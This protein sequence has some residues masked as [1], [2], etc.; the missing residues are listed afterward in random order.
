[1]SFNGCVVYSRI[2]YFF[3]KAK[4]YRDTQVYRAFGIGVLCGQ[5]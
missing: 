5:K 1:M 3:L 2:L 4:V